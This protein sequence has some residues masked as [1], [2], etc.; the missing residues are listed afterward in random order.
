MSKIRIA[1]LASGGG[2]NL[3]AIIDATKESSFNAEIAVVVVN[4]KGAYAKERAEQAGIP[5]FYVGKGNCAS[6]EEMSERM[7]SIF[8]THQID[9]IVLA[10]YLSILSESLVK[11]Y[12][13]RIIN[14]HPSLIPKYCGMHFHGEHVHQAVLDAGE[15]VSGAT[16]HFVDAGVD[17]GAVISQMEV[18][19]LKD[20]TVETLKNRVLQV[21]HHLLV[22]V[23]RGIAHGRIQIGVED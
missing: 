8:E 16:V 13:K 1:V 22:A 15:A 9:L 2:S 21:E 12:E 14:I 4:R 6:T 18:M 11:R 3:Q 23:I 7:L 20:D 19:V 5:T 10:G 17:T